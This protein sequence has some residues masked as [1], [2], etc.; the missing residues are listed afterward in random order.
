MPGVHGLVSQIGLLNSQFEDDLGTGRGAF[1]GRGR[2]LNADFRRGLTCLID[3]QVAR[4][5]ACV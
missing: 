4:M 3:T 5:N 2:S 1:Q